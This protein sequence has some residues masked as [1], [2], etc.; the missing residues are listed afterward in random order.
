M[1]TTR[2]IPLLILLL[3][4]CAFTCNRKTNNSNQKE[5]TT[6]TQ[7]A[8]I[9]GNWIVASLQLTN[10]K[11]TNL[12]KYYTVNI[13]TESIG[14]NLDINQCGA[15]CT[16][17]KD[18]IVIDRFMS[19]TEACCDKAIAMDIAKFLSG[20][21]HYSIQNGILKLSNE[22]GIISLSQPTNNLVGSNWKA[23]NYRKKDADKSITF[24][25]SYMLAFEA[26]SAILT[27]DV[28]SCS[29]AVSF[30]KE[31]FEIEHEMGCS[32]ACCDSK[33]GTLLKNMLTGKN[34]YSI[35]EDKMIVTNSNHIIEFKK[36][37]ISEE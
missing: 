14:L 31:A 4:T 3:L 8:D 20:T 5:T 17:K 24:T 9:T 36:S 25:K 1:I 35:N 12:K 30:S 13:K 11:T 23:L 37:P 6:I 19:C 29:G 33:D 21:L 27:L 32:R 10:K 2:F 15:N 26:M 16:I 34:T 28:N 22:K 7:A 18:S